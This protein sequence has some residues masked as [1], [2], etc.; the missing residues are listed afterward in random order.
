MRILFDSKEE[1]YK[2]PF[3]AIKMGQVCYFNI[4]VPESC[5]AEKVYIIFEMNGKEICYEMQRFESKN[6]YVSFKTELFFD[7]PGLYFYRFYIKKADGG[8]NLFKQ[9]YTDTNMEAGEKWQL[10][11]YDSSYHAPEWAKGAVIYQIFPD[12][13]NK[14]GKCDLSE[15]LLPFKIHANFSD[16][17]DCQPDDEGNWNNDFFGG[18]LAGIVEKLDYIK[19]LGVDTIYLNPIVKAFSNHRYDTADYLSVDPMLG[20]LNDFKNLCDE[21]HKRNIKIIFDG[22]YNHTGKRSIYF[23][24]AVNDDKS[25]YKDWY[26]FKN[27]PHDYVSWWGISTLPQIKK[28][29][30]DFIKFI[31]EK[32]IPFW[33]NLGADGVRLDVADELT[34]EFIEKISQSAKNVKQE[35]LVI[36][37][38][39]EDASNKIS[40]GEQRRYLL[41]RE[42]DS[43]MNYPFLNAIVGFVKGEKSAEQ[44]AYEVMTITENYPPD[45]LNCSMNMLSTHDTARILTQL[46]GNKIALK[47]AMFLQFMLPGSPSI[48]YGDEIGMEG[49]KDP[50]NR[51]YFKWDDMNFELRGYVRKLCELKHRFPQLRT[52]RIKFLNNENTVVFIRENLKIVVNM[53]DVTHEENGEI[54]FSENTRE[55]K[56]NKYGFAIINNATQ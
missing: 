23:E 21:S 1:K 52:G 54:I 34:D 13:Y 48:Y 24:S 9:G 40:Y 8:F 45:I 3:G 25:P 14:K 38:V 42:L 53:T 26:D 39:W 43:V 16:S 46:D 50:F 20:N 22:V 28:G 49:G 41:G 32:V 51:G 29:H 33:L 30:P 18:N 27:F 6:E 36:G 31:T 4:L 35:A 7:I 37:E 2:K 11:C 10:T 15:K 44:F 56:I 55:N 5:P 12:R 47:T 17:P 19:D